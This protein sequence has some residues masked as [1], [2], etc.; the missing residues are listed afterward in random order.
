MQMQAPGV[1]AMGVPPAQNN[2]MAPRSAYAQVQY[3]LRSGV[4][5][6]FAAVLLSA[7]S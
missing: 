6:V 5:V 7:L 2:G 3:C 4:S 1:V